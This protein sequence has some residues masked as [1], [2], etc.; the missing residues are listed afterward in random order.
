MKRGLLYVLLVPPALLL[1]LVSFGVLWS[2]LSLFPPVVSVVAGILLAVAIA[3]WI[4]G[5]RQSSTLVVGS[6]TS[7][8]GRQSS[9]DGL[10]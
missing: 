7:L 6:E 4:V 8:M 2:L 3:W 5:R 1:C 10:L 9:K